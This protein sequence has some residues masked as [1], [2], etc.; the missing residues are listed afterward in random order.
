MLNDFDQFVAD[1]GPDAAFYTPT[2]VRELHVQ[3]HT[4]AKFLID[5][6]RTERHPLKKGRSPQ[7]KVDAHHGDR[8][9]DRSAQCLTPPGDAEVSSANPP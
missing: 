1:L 9:I 4:L 6:Y 2:E 8:N 3:V 7:V 5:V